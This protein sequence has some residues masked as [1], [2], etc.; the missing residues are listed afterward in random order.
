VSIDLDQ[1]GR[2]ALVSEV[3]HD[4]L[5]SGLWL[6]TGHPT[7]VEAAF[8]RA[9][10][11]ALWFGC[12]VL[13]YDVRGVCCGGIVPEIRYYTPPFTD[14]HRGANISSITPSSGELFYRDDAPIVPATE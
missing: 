5:R 9:K 11:L 7:S 6:C 13:I 14:A 10:R 4:Y 8:E 2:Q 12:S 3:A 1:L